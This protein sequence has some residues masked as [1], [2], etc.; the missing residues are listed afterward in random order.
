LE[1]YRFLP[2]KVGK[3][4]LVNSVFSPLHKNL[5]FG[6]K[7][8]YR[9]FFN[10]TTHEPAK[11]G[12]CNEPERKPKQTNDNE[13]RD[14]GGERKPEG[15][16]AKYYMKLGMVGTSSCGKTTVAKQM[17]ILHRNGFSDEEKENYKKILISNVIFAFREMVNQS[18]K[19]GIAIE[20]QEAGQAL[21][22]ADPYNSTLT[23]E[24][25]NHIKN[26]WKDDG[27]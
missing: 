10:Q 17:Q 20:H 3:N 22:T 21:T 25:V 15:V 12:G 4:C 6:S 2:T 9:F 1:S 23:P 11:M 5:I 8:L 19:R 24:L 27:N 14:G 7:S 26:L 16:K 18:K 13:G